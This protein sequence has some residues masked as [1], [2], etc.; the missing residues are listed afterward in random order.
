MK[1]VSSQVMAEIDRNSQERFHIPGLVL[2]ENAGAN[3]FRKFVELWT[4]NYP[5]RPVENLRL[6]C[7][8][9]GGNNGGDVLVLARHAHLFGLRN[10]RVV[11]RNRRLNAQAEV[12]YKIVE[13]LG[14]PVEFWEEEEA[15]AREY[16]GEADVIFDGIA[17]TGLKGAL[18]SSAADLVEAVNEN[19]DAF[20][21]AIDI[22][23]GLGQGFQ[24]TYPAVRADLSITMGLPKTP[25]YTPL[26]RSYAGRIELVSPGFPA[27][28]L[29]NPSDSGRFFEAGEERV[30]QKFS[31]DAADAAAY[32]GDRGH[33]AVFAG[34]KG[35][36][37]AAVMT[38]ES[39]GRTGS[40]LVTLYTDSS[41]YP[42]VAN[43]LV[44]AMVQI[45][46]FEGDAGADSKDDT[47]ESGSFDLSR[48]SALLAGPGWGR[49]GR[50]GILRRLIQSGLPGVCDA[51]GIY[52]LSALIEEEGVASLRGFLSG[53]WVLTPHPGECM[54]LMR[55]LDRQI[56]KD[57][58]LA[59]PLELLRKAAGQLNAV[60]VLKTHV[61]WIVAP[62]GDY[63]VIDGMNPAMGTGG[64]GDVLAG[65]IAGLM[66]RGAEAYEAAE[67]GVVLHQEAG[68]LASKERG[69]FLAEDLPEYVSALLGGRCV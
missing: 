60:L 33:V 51:D 28:L 56:S 12:H 59:Q 34:T 30:W 38:S 25:L 20:R 68:R 67:A 42:I 36:I 10:L 13:S 58:L 6:V 5:Q 9:G 63:S 23:S 64:S 62:G 31:T 40:G 26:G 37:G 4:E 7:V 41:V 46:P 17:G 61:L 48:F 2:M 45:T 44:S 52:A 47:S 39:A 32:K 14:I 27:E 69:W 19:A 18:H 55:S 8:A 29:E 22:P 43:R 11:M 53:N 50:S 15:R 3:A 49:S 57:E 35:T 1:I 65:I 24:K 16:I 21:V 54:S 66:G